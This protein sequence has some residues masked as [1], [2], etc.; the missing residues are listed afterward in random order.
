MIKVSFVIPAYNEEKNIA[1]CIASIL[2]QE[3][4]KDYEII[5][6]NDGS[7]DKTSKIVKG[8]IKKNKSIQLLDLKANKGRGN[9]RYIGVK[10][11]GEDYVSFVDADIILP[12]HWLKTCL[13]NLGEGFD[14]VGGIAVPD[15]DVTYISQRF[16]LNPKIIPHTT[17]ITGSNAIYKK[18]VFREIELN[19]KLRGGEDT[20]LNWKIDKAGFK[21]KLISNLTVEHK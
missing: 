3:E 21:I 5:V 11:A 2:H 15:G 17:G 4:L 10:K 20:D 13:K 19:S 18:E 1:N 14:A 8:L 12:K 6:V 7:K 16:K 9:A